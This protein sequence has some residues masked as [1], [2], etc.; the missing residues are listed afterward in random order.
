MNVPSKNK[1]PH[2]WWVATLIERFEY[3][4][5][6]KNN[7]RRRC[8]AWVNTVILKAE[9]REQ[10]FKKAVEYGELGN[11]EKSDWSDDKDRKGK[12]VFE[13][14]SSLLPVY[15]EIDP[16]GTEIIF[17]DYA[18]ISVGRVRSWIR[19]KEQLEAFDDSE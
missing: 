11:S 17:D 12:W 9:D 10:A 4:H 5:E 19:S 14:I 15:D 7:P 13:G 18:D 2:G 6:D 3:D 8:R 1:S 16:V